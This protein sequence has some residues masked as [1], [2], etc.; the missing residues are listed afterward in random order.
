MPIAHTTDSS[1]NWSDNLQACGP[2]TPPTS[3]ASGSGTLVF[4]LQQTWRA[5]SLIT[6]SG[7]PLQTDVLNYYTNHG[8][9]TNMVTPAR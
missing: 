7:V 6:G 9:V 4:T 8:A 1:S 5:G 3:D 2:F